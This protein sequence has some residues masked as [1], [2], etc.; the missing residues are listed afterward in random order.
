M[1]INPLVV[2]TTED[3]QI[4]GV[5]PMVADVS[6][7]GARL[8]HALTRWFLALAFVVGVTNVYERPPGSS[9][10]TVP[11]IVARLAIEL[12]WLLGFVVRLLGLFLL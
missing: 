4:G 8:G 7:R 9:V 3:M 2:L 6:E 11:G 5:W 10:G 1:G 12:R